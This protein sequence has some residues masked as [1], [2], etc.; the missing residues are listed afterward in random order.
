MNAPRLLKAFSVAALG[1]LLGACQ[2]L[3]PH[4]RPAAYQRTA[5]EHLQS[6]CQ[7]QECP[8][9]NIDTVHFAD[10]PELNLLVD[11]GLLEL[12]REGEGMPLPASLQSHERDFLASAKPGWSSYLQAKVREQNDGRVLMELSSYRFTGG[13]HGMPERTFIDFDRQRKKA[14]E[15]HDLL[16]PEQ[17]AAFWEK[18]GQA[19]Q[20]W[21]KGQEQEGNTGIAGT[22]PFLRTS[23]IGLARVGVL[24]LYDVN[25]IAP[26]SSGH[27]LLV[28]PYPQLNG[29]LRP[30]YFPKA[31]R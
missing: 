23:H 7:G 29:I 10:E 18:A 14:L 24:L 21:L 16:L 27:P 12:T 26:Y 2:S 20:R 19:H 11:R 13:A 31:R 8:L 28:V 25:R 1:L 17:E 6:G 22:W 30:E 9:V 15:L 5:W 3:S 4:S